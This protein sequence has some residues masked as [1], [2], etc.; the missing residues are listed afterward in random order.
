MKIA[1]AKWTSFFEVAIHEWLNK[2]IVSN[3]KSLLPS[4]D[5][6]RMLNIWLKNDDQKK[7]RNIIILFAK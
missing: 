6:K 2:K 1:T 5:L 3:N 7:P 4:E